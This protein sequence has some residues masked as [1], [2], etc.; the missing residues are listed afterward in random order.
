[1]FPRLVRPFGLPLLAALLVAPAA[2]AQTFTK[3]T[4]GPIATSPVPGDALYVGC[5]WADYDADGD[6]DFYIVRQGLFRNDGAGAFVKVLTFPSD[7]V[8]A[9]GCSWADADND[10]DLDLYVSGGP[11]GGSVFYR[12]DGGDTFV[13]V[14]AGILG[15]VAGNQGWGCAWGDYDRDGLVDLFISSAFGFNDLITSNHLLHNEGALAFSRIDTSAVSAA[16]G[17]Y[18]I[19]TWNDF[20]EDGDPDVFIGSGPATGVLAT[21]F[22][23]ENRHA[24]ASPSFF[25]RVTTGALAT[26]LHDGQI[27]NWVDI[28]ADGDLDVYLTNYG[29]PAAGVA[30]DLYRNDNGTFHRMT[31]AAAGPIVSDVGHSLA[32]VWSDFDNDGDMDCV[33]TNDG[34][35]LSAYYRNDGSGLFTS[36]LSTALRSFGPHYGAAAADYDR[37]GDVDLYMHGTGATRG[38]FRNGN[39]ASASTHWLAVRCVGTASNRAA[40]GTRVQVVATIGGVRRRL[41]QEVSAQNSF[42]GH[43]AFELH[44]GLGEAT[45]ADSVIVRFAGGA[46]HVLSSP[47][48][49]RLIVIEDAST[50]V[51]GSVVHAEA[52]PDH[53]RLSWHIGEASAMTCVVYRRIGGES[54]LWRARAELEIDGTG[55]VTFEDRAVEPGQRLGYRI[56]VMDEGEERFV[57]ETWLEIP[58]HGPSLEWL[59][60]NP[61]RQSLRFAVTLPRAG[62]VAAS[63]VDVA[64]RAARRMSPG[65][66]GAGRHELQFDTGATLSPGVYWL[67][68]GHAAGVLQRRVVVLQ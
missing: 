12:N 65:P 9:I 45:T 55:R 23:Y 46:M 16:T 40:I 51:T 3:I 44:F 26:D 22:I 50:A 28:D 42:G 43:N 14:A 49:Q 18:T 15:D 1:M 62:T 56:G 34:P 68:V 5:A 48:N 36:V 60:G 8:R 7:H 39:P 52:F 32:S 21:D 61:A 13:K 67:R 27:Y 37:D 11:P 17:P 31:A 58:A 10:G 2:S 30:N 38:L 33:V 20:D 54:D 66:L 19:P 24:G 41:V 64:G 35:E 4:S 47:A 6:P 57:G 25:R 59:G 29:G 63:L 53:A